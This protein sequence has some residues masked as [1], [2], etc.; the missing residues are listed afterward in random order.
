MRLVGAPGRTGIYAIA[1][2][3]RGVVI[4]LKKL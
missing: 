3:C 1:N 4:E 2:V